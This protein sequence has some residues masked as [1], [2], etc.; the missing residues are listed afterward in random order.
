MLDRSIDEVFRMNRFSRYSSPRRRLV[1]IRMGVAA[2]A[3]WPLGLQSTFA[4]VLD[5]ISNADAGGALKEAL[6]K[7]AD[8][9]VAHLGVNGGFLNNPKVKIPLPDGLRKVEKL[10]RATGRG[11]ELDSLVESMNHAAEMA[12]PESR[13][14]LAGAIKSMTVQDA[15]AIVAGGEDSVTQFF[16]GKTRV[17]LTE[18]F[19]PV[20]TR[21]VGKLG[22][23]QR[24]NSLAGQGMKLGLVKEDSATIERYVTGKA[25]DGLY[26][27]IAEE[28][29]AIR[30]NPLEAG[31][32]LLGK[33]FGALH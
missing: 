32:K 4:G 28:E 6:S 2:A 30:Q 14:M 18:K 25:L 33:V 29:R 21:S 7:G 11:Q 24:Y 15:R 19:L 5:G 27:M 20:V 26:S 10:L 31:S 17:P 13:Q 3:L 1:C 12:V 23:A 8:S 16:K 9:A 22:L